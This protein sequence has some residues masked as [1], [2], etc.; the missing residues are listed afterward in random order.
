M[1]FFQQYIDNPWVIGIGTG[2]ISGIFV[3][4]LTRIIL[5][6]LSNK[7]Y[8]QRVGLANQEI[9]YSL[10][11]NIPEQIIF[12]LNIIESLINSTAR[13]Y[14]VFSKDMYQP[15]EIAEELIK[16]IIDSSFISAEAKKDYCNQLDYLF[17]KPNVDEHKKDYSLIIANN[18]DKQRRNK[19]LSIILGVVISLYSFIFMI[20][21]IKTEPSIFNIGTR[22][23]VFSLSLIGI[24][25]LLTMILAISLQIKQSKE[26]YLKAFSKYSD[27]EVESILKSSKQ[28]KK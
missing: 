18:E 22:L 8:L 3:T 23:S 16:E 11:S 20:F 25:I 17:V 10:K 24:S 9:I 15:K 4:F 21:I 1:N 13:S 28:E 26:R 19:Q 27:E 7:E 2:L 6:K 12:P 5:S 14:K